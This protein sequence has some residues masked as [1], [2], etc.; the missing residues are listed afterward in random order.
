[1]TTK[2]FVALADAIRKENTQRVA[3]DAMPLFNDEHIVL[4]AD[5]CQASNQ[6]FNRAKWLGYVTT[7]WKEDEA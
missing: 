7:P 1:M 5:V 2:E 3:K 4:L 6:R